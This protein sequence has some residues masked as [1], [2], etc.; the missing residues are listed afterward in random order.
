MADSWQVRA[1][2][3]EGALSRTQAI[4]GGLTRDEVRQRLR[5]GR[6]Q[7]VHPGVY[8]TF[9]GPLPFLARVWAALLH[10]GPAAVV[11]HRTAAKL[12]GLL[13]ADPAQIDLS[14]PWSHRVTPIAGTRIHRS[15]RHGDRCH[16]S[17]S[18]PQTQV[19]DTVLDLVVQATG[20]DDVVG[21]L[22][23]ACQRRLTTPARLREAAARRP[24]MRHRALVNA[25]LADAAAG[26]ASP[27]ERRYRRDVERAHALPDASRNVA[28]VLRGRRWYYDV[29]YGAW[30]L[31]VELEGLAYHPVDEVW[32]D[33]VRDNA[34]VLD[35][36]SVLR[37][38]WRAVVS[39]PCGTA[40]EVVSALRARGWRG[41][42]QACGPT[43]TLAVAA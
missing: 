37:Y 28:V 30:R 18:L 21:W 27:L 8:V 23:R 15:R 40:A 4:A 29:R 34:A 41:V 42:P 6:W 12:Q 26:V 39:N 7:L 35:G 20:E 36:D 17:R 10:A 19:A 43:C 25:V 5:A 38:G 22:T 16:P 3:Q 31:R 32:R 2:Q 11:S 14:V 24:R 13:D 1:D 33:D 9:T